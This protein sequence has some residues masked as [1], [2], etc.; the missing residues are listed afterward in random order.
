MFE[1]IFHRFFDFLCGVDYKK[2]INIFVVVFLFFGL[3][4]LMALLISYWSIITDLFLL[5]IFLIVKSTK[6]NK[7]IFVLADFFLKRYNKALKKRDLFIK[8][9]SIR[10]IRYRFWWLNKYI[11]ILYYLILISKTTE[12]S[13]DA[14]L[15]S[16]NYLY[17]SVLTQ[18]EIDSVKNNELSHEDKQKIYD[19]I[20][21]AHKYVQRRTNALS[22]LV[23][24]G[25]IV[26]N[27]LAG[28]F[29]SLIFPAFLSHAATFHWVQTDWSTGVTANNALHT[30]DQSGWTEYSAR[31]DGVVATDSV[32]LSGLPL[33]T[34]AF[35]FTNSA[36][37]V[38]EDDVTGT[39]FVAGVAILKSLGSAPDFP[40]GG[41]DHSG[42]DWTPDDGSTITG[43]HYNVGV[44]T[45]T[46]GY[47]VYVGAGVELAVS[48]VTAN[49]DGILSA[50]GKGDPSG[51]G[52]GGAGG[53][54]NGSW[55]AGGGGGGGAG[56]GAIG[57]NGSTKHGS[58][59]A[60]GGGT[61]YGGETASSIYLG[62][63]GGDGGSGNC[64]SSPHNAVA[65]AVGGGAIHIKTSAN[66]T[67]SGSILANGNNGSNGYSKLS[68][69]NAGAGGSGGGSGGGI[70]LEGDGITMSGILSANGGNGGDGGCGEN[71]KYSPGGGAGGRIKLYYSSINLTGSLVVTGGSGGQPGTN[72]Q[73]FTTTG[74]T[75]ANGTTY[76]TVKG[77]TTA[78]ASYVTSAAGSQLDTSTWASIEGISFT[79]TIPKIGRAHV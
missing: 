55:G 34:A 35:D 32:E 22:V 45:I 26:L 13:F 7:D 10:N 51:T 6:N 25:L 21:H 38:Q 71:C 69:G 9:L 60:G 49:I 33:G 39:Q 14:V 31:D 78:T 59:P 67:A 48:A 2:P 41:T 40:A 17:F 74:A 50:N 18:E 30:T 70:V 61:E 57:G 54:G 3:G 1:S 44:F 47:T 28:L 24:T 77:Y 43:T 4:T 20:F 8:Y 79:Q 73:G 12:K 27:I 16:V 11:S 58:S 76:S 15:D 19:K 56:Y 37:Y 65:G 72:T 42:A 36:D 64:C 46:T 5:T 68:G 75:G 23:M 66:I 29:I 53:A 52:N 63:N 62:S